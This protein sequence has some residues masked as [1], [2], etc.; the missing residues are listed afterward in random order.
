LSLNDWRIERHWNFGK[1]FDKFFLLFLNFL[2][3]F[4][5]KPSGEQ[6]FPSGANLKSSNPVRAASQMITIKLIYNN[7]GVD[8]FIENHF[9]EN[10]LS[11][12]RFIESLLYQKY[13]L[14]KV[15]YIES[16]FCRKYVLSNGFI[17]LFCFWY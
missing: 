14:S 15:Y 3:K 4:C 16:T 13:V 1:V 12:V 10:L 6:L 7:I 5:I 11:K 2:I 17:F 8:R 9:I